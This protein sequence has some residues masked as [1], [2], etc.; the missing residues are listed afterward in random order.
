MRE[1]L[2]LFDI[3]K[4]LGLVPGDDSAAAIDAAT[5]VIDSGLS[6][7]EALVLLRFADRSKGA[8][9]R[10]IRGPSRFGDVAA[11]VSGCRFTADDQPAQTSHHQ[12]ISAFP[13]SAILSL[14]V[15][16]DALDAGIPYVEASEGRRAIWRR[17]LQDLPKPL[18][19]IAWD[20]TR[21][22]L[23]LDDLRNAIGPFQGTLVS[24]VWDGGPPQLGAWPEIIDA[25]VHFSSLAD[26]AA[27]IAEIDAVIGP[28]GLPLH[29][30]GSMGAPALVLG[31]PNA[32][33]Y[34]HAEADRASWYPSVEV[35]KTN[36]IG[37][38]AETIGDVAA[39][40]EKFMSAVA[41]P[42][43]NRGERA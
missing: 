23:L 15:P 43:R 22:G 34:W 13:L 30:A 28:D 32:P 38:W 35:L 36:H 18:I 31:Q 8:G 19:G 9:Q 33:W 42:A 7:L 29:V 17:S 1:V 14:P 21:P 24:L 20:Q 2:P 39:G 3:D 27:L 12:T 4:A 26:L 5:I 40:L 16:A 10:D 37:N 6:T 41:E 11:L 25:G